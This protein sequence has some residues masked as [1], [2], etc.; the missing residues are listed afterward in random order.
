MIDVMNTRLGETLRRTKLLNDSI[1][2]L[3]ANTTELKMKAI[4]EWIQ[5]DQLTEKGVDSKNQIIGF[6][7]LA[8]EFITDGRKREGDPYDLNDSGSFYRSMFV[9]LLRDAIVFDADSEKMSDQ[10][11]WK[12][13]I[14]NLTEE[15]LQKYTDEIRKNYVKYARK[16]LGID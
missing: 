6:Y 8:T 11:W 13:E 4:R 3:E 14:L 9:L 1:A 15:N 7:S 12:N 2:W 5:K 16:I 10:H